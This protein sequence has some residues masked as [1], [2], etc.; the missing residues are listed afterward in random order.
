MLS[1]DE[2]LRSRLRKSVGLQKRFIRSRS[3]SVAL[4]NVAAGTTLPDLAGLEG[5]SVL[6]LTKDML[7]AALALI[8]LDG[9]AARVIICP[10]DLK[11]DL[12]P[13]VAEMGRIDAVVFDEGCPAILRAGI[14]A[15]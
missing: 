2:P 5:R 7:S 12:L 14:V 8:E 6:L 13:L 3:R 11:N 15:A 9:V 4:A 1:G 10:P